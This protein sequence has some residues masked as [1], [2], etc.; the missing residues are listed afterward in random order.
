MKSNIFIFLTL[1]QL[2]HAQLDTN[3]V[4]F[5]ATPVNPVP[6]SFNSNPAGAELW[7][8]GV[9][10]GMTNNSLFL[11]PGTYR[12]K[13]IRTGFIPL[14]DKIIIA[15]GDS[16]KTFNYKLLMNAG[17]LKL[18]VY[19]SN[20]RIRINKRV[21][22]NDV[23]YVLSPGV[24][25]IQVDADNYV[26]FS[27][28]VAITIG[29]SITKTIF[30]KRYTGKL[31]LT[32]NPPK[33]S[34][35]L[36]Q[37]G[38][39]LYSWSGLKIID[40]IAEGTY[41]LQAK[42][43]GYKKITSKTVIK[44]NQTTIKNIQ[45]TAGND[46]PEAF[47]SVEG[48]SFIENGQKWSSFFISKYEVTCG[49]WDSIMG[50][51]RSAALGKLKPISSISLTEI[52]TFCN[53]LSDSEGLD[54]AYSWNAEGLICDFSLSGYRLPTESEWDYA[55]KGGKKSKGFVFSGSNDINKVAWYNQNSN[56]KLH[57]VGTKKPNELGIYD[58]SGNVCEC[59][60]NS[61]SFRTQCGGAFNYT[62]R[63]CRTDSRWYQSLT[64]PSTSIGF[65][66]VRTN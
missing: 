64:F 12:L 44:K 13:L 10:K 21:Y 28:R 58:M 5:N 19:P 53:A 47:V 22:K 48:K 59:V 66:V 14:S 34:C 40:S 29:G 24:Y 4:A 41:E 33:A 45:M 32:I 2:L 39:A 15:T 63:N 35:I 8:D 38:M 18:E 56:G 9:K 31:E 54:R 16:N 46:L 26:P 27:D 20:A 17:A 50:E 11:N 43:S 62:E 30:L 51:N 36:Y 42:A 52:I 1:V 60:M 37:N 55:A 7:F 25:W 61:G 6:V 49:L 65:R 23:V 3:E 57:D